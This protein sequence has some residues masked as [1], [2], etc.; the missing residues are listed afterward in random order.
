MHLYNVNIVLSSSLESSIGNMATLHLASIINNNLDH[1]LNI[2]SFYNNHRILPI[3][4]KNSE[5]VE[6]KK[7]KGLGLTL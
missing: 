4:N 2:F 3:Y 1:G 6:I 5:F 7:C